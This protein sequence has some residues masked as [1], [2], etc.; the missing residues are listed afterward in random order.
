MAKSRYKMF[1]LNQL[2]R[3]KAKTE[4][5]VIVLSICLNPLISSNPTSVVA[6]T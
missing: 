5:L 1:Y 2:H 3:L 6:Q 4:A